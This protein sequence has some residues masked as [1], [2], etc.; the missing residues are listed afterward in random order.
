MTTVL[1]RGHNK[2]R[3]RKN[4]IGIKIATVILEFKDEKAEVVSFGS[5]KFTKNVFFRNYLCYI[6]TLKL[7]EG[8][9]NERKGK[10]REIRYARS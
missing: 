4:Q 8:E 9:N 5:G 6:N 2:E 1:N 7:N 3:I 10:K